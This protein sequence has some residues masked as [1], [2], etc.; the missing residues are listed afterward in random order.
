M[1]SNVRQRES[2]RDIA[3]RLILNEAPSP[4]SPA[5]AHG[6]ADR[7]GNVLIDSLLKN[8]DALKSVARD[9]GD[10]ALIIAAAIGISG[11][12]SRFDKESKTYLSGMG[13]GF[14]NAR[15]TE[16][17]VSK[18]VPFAD[19]SIGPAQMQYSRVTDD[20]KK[21]LGIQS[22]DD[23]T[24]NVKAVLAAAIYLSGLYTRAKA[25]GYS[26]DKPGQ[27]SGVKKGVFT[28]T[29]NAALDLAIAAYNG[30]PDR[31]LTRYYIAPGKEIGTRQR[32]GEK[33]P[34]SKLDKDYIPAYYGGDAEPTD[35]EIQATDA[36]VFRN[37]ADYV[38]H[39]AEKFPEIHYNVRRIMG[40]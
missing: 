11:N 20:V 4:S 1:S 22:P 7:Y 9:P 3:R 2:L 13:R 19:P 32:E 25:L 38:S 37:T 17:A 33:L 24:D 18:Y 29:G 40:L 10:Q 5:V 27:R 14:L 35:A 21:T 39:V 34:N 16:I 36:Q 31:V 6:K 26:T 12:E 23:M 30:D 8:R 15:D 28:S